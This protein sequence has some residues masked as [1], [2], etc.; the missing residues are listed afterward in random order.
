M[1]DSGWWKAKHETSGK[2]GWVPKDFLTLLSKDSPAS[3]GSPRFGTPPAEPSPLPT[4]PL[5][6]PNDSA[7]PISI[8]VK[9]VKNS[10]TF[11]SGS[12]DSKTATK[13]TAPR[14]FTVNTTG[15]TKI[16]E[17]S[18]PKADKDVILKQGYLVKVKL[19]C[20]LILTLM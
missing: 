20:F 15:S 2:M 13:T 16:S 11:L 4:P 1:D 19:H 7:R 5:N 18:S 10:D 14:R 9:V 17:P 3:P 12:Y 6:P 8:N